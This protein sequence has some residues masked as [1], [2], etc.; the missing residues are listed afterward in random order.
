MPGMVLCVFCAGGCSSERAQSF[1]IIVSSG[2]DALW[3]LKPSR[4]EWH[5]C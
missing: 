3:F 4:V 1:L 5:G 2:R